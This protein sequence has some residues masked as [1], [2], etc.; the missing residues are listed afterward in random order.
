MRGLRHQLIRLDHRDVGE[1]TEVRF[2]PPDALVRGHHRIVVR[3]RVL[4][5]DVQTMH[6]HD[7]AR[8][9]VTHCGADPEHD[10]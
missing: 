3:G 2:E 7:V 10:T 1:S 9:P 8:L 4:V 6:G 5:V